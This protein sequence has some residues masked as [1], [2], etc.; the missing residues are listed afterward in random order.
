[1]QVVSTGQ[2]EY[3][4]EVSGKRHEEAVFGRPEKRLDCLACDAATAATSS[5]RPG[6]PSGEKDNLDDLRFSVAPKTDSSVGAS[7]RLGCVVAT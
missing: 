4:G 2:K 5:V 3:F 6:D 7:D 1:M